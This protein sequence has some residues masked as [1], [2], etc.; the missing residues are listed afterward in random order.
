MNTVLFKIQSFALG[1]DMCKMSANFWLQ[2]G[3]KFSFSV[4]YGLVI[5][6]QKDACWT[7]YMIF[8]LCTLFSKIAIFEAVVKIPL[9]QKKSTIF[10]FFSLE[11]LAVHMQTMNLLK[12][13]WWNKL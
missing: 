8:K 3:L 9:L 4:V 10:V 1:L 13:W 7:L 11:P 12:I 2:S 6:V 5:N